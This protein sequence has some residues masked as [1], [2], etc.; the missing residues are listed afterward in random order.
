MLELEP[1]II[2][3]LAGLPGLRGVHALAALTDEKTKPTPCAYVAYDG[4]SVAENNSDGS[5]ARLTVRWLVVLAVK[6]VAHASGAA[7]RDDAAPLV[8][9]LLGRLMG[10]QP[11]SASRPLKLVDLPQPDYR[12]GTLLLPLVFET[13][14]F[15][16]KDA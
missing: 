7:A 8:S 14:Q 15:V 4:A 9:A 1:Q 6:N 10:W 5:A 16:K 3:R 11:A 12:N 13:L 2:A